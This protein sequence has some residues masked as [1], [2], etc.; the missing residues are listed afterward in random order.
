MRT[1]RD[2][3]PGENEHDEL[4]RKGVAAAVE[5]VIVTFRVLLL[6]AAKV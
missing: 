2:Y 5:A 1:S 3:R 4:R 6:E